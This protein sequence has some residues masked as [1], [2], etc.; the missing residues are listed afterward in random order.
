MVIPEDIKPQEIDLISKVAN[1]V[2]DVL[3]HPADGGAL[4]KLRL[5][6]ENATIVVNDV[7]EEA[8]LFKIKN[9]QGEWE[10]ELNIPE[11]KRIERNK[12]F[13]AEANAII[14]CFPSGMVFPDMF[15]PNDD[16]SY[17]DNEE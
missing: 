2:F 16:F 7:I 11:G 6:K 15:V 8:C 9:E 13:E 4:R 1:N 17:L 12:N 3:F 14:S 5:T 10:Y